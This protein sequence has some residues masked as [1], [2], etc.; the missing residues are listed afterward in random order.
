MKFCMYAVPT[1]I[2]LSCLSLCSMDNGSDCIVYKQAESRDRVG[3]LQLINEQ[4]HT[5]SS[6]I[7]VLPKLFRELAIRDSVAKERLFVAQRGDETV[8]FKKLYLISDQQEYDTIV[9]NELRCRYP[10]DSVSIRINGVKTSSS[11]VPNFGYHNSICV[12]FGG[13][14]TAP[15]YRNAGINS[16]LTRKAF[17]VITHHAFSLI[18]QE[19]L[20]MSQE[21]KLR[22][23]VLLYG[24]TKANAGE[25]YG[26]VDRN[27]SIIRAFTRFVTHLAGISGYDSDE[28]IVHSCYN[29][30][31]PTFDPEATECVPLADDKAVAGYGNAL[32]FPLIK[33]NK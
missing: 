15:K 9:D 2:M 14:Y 12:Y 29:S 32:I 30:F 7:V 20:S 16:H 4:A 13:D 21:Q 25:G 28:S 22:Y 26:E 19:V 3:V 8:A 11:A 6:R 24:L 33:K 18:E 31:M 5:D 17:S 1:M 23:I 27:P 10:Q